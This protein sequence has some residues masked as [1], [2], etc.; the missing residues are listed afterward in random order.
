MLELEQG[1]RACRRDFV[2]VGELSEHFR[3]S[4]RAIGADICRIYIIEGLAPNFIADLADHF[5]MEPAFFMGQERTTQWGFSFE[6]S[7]NMLELPSLMDLAKSFT[8]KY[9]EPRNF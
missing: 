2:S 3:L 6:G 8:I 7:R 1:K 5:Q 9:Y 4:P